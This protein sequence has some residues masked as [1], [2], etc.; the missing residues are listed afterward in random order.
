[1]LLNGLTRKQAHFC[2]EY[3]ASGFRDPSGSY[4][5]AYPLASKRTAQNNASGLLADTR[6][7]AYIDRAVASLPVVDTINPEFV[8][9]SLKKLAQSATRDSDKIRALELLG[10]YLKI[11]NDAVTVNTGLSLQ[12]LKDLKES[13]NTVVTYSPNFVLE[14]HGDTK[15]GSPIPT[16]MLEVKDALIGDNAVREEV[17]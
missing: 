14:P 16:P 13:V 5:K 10:K 12:D 15:T 11:F 9:S 2:D 4:Q 8:I 3:I 1:M 7:K 6:I 17:I